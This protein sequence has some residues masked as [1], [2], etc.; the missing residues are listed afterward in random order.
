MALEVPFFV[1]ITKIDSTSQ[2]RLTSTV[3][4][5]EATLKAAG[6]NK[7]PLVGKSEDDCITAASNS[8]KK[9]TVPIFCVS[10]VSGSGLSDIK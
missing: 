5:V 1:V 9:N 10:S 7:M 2:E 4:A 8:L 6:S 3:E